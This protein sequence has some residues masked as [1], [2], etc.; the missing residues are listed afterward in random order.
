[1]IIILQNSICGMQSIAT[2]WQRVYAIHRC[3]LR[4]SVARSKHLCF[5]IRRSVFSAL[6]ILL[7]M[8]YEKPYSPLTVDNSIKF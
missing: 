2:L 6:E 5:Q 4:V 1:M 8:R 7:P 3:P